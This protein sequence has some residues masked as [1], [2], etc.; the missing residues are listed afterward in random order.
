MRLVQYWGDTCQ[1]RS[2][3]D[4]QCVGCYNNIDIGGRDRTGLDA[5]QD[6]VGS[7]WHVEH[8]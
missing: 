6:I 5:V 2:A 8:V 7:G 4:R 1:C 3:R